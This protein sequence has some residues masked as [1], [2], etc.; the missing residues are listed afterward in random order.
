MANAFYTAAKHDFPTGDVQWGLSDIK[1]TLVNAGYT[2]SAAHTT[3]ADLGANVLAGI[4]NQALTGEA[5]SAGGVAS[6]DS[7]TF[8]GVTAAQTLKA[9]ILYD[10][11]GGGVTRLIAY[12]DT[13]A[14]FGLTT[15]GA[16][17]TVDWNGTP[18]NGTV[19]TV[20]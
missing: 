12:F 9:L 20:S 5:V 16:D 2:F 17:I 7:V 14:G 4:T 10:D 8:A 15:T 3:L 18:A 1:A 19:F 11:Q 6:A 13:G